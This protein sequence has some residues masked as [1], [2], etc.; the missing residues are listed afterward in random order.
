MHLSATCR[1]KLQQFNQCLP[2]EGKVSILWPDMFDYAGPWSGNGETIQIQNLFLPLSNK[3]SYF[4]INAV[5]CM[6]NKMLL[7]W[8]FTAHSSYRLQKKY[9]ARFS[10][11]RASTDP[12]KNPA[13][14]FKGPSCSFFSISLCFFL[15]R[16]TPRSFSLI[17]PHHFPAVSEAWNLPPVANLKNQINRAHFKTCLVQTPQGRSTK[18]VKYHKI[19]VLKVK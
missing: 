13:M 19:S 3:S 14:L 8:L 7:A 16:Q 1:I 9:W 5:R 18:N 10:P 2:L 17:R 15:A 12:E 11:G 6:D 4:P